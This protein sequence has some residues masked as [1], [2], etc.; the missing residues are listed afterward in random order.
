MKVYQFIVFFGIVLIIY[1]LVN[2]YIFSRFI[3]AIPADS[4]VR[5]WAII[6][7]WVLAF[8]FVVARI[9]ERAYPCDF[10][11]VMTWIGSF[12]LG[13]M[14]YFLMIVLLIDVARVIHHFL[15]FFPQIFYA[16]Y[17]KTKLITLLISMGLITMI[18]GA[19]FINARNTKIKVIDLQIEKKIKGEKTLKIAMASDIHLGTLVGRRGASR[20]VRMINDLHPDIILFAGDIVDEDLKPVIRRNLG[21]MLKTLHAPLGVWAVTGNHEY[22]GGAKEAVAYLKAH[23]ICFLSDT[24]VL[25]DDRF[26]LAGRE[27]RDRSRFMGKQRKPLEEILKDVDR[28]YPIILMDHQPFQLSVPEKL[29]VDLQLSG[30]THHGQIWPFNYITNAMYELSWGYLKKGNTQFYVSSGF[31]T[32]GPPVRLGNRPEIVSITLH[33]Q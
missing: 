31:G 20:L 15:P 6:A 19:G 30:H 12:W 7:F 23:N 1:G 16:D 10:T 3:Q 9:R 8:S 24:A 17:Q 28:S 14:V 22:I 11:E 21:E 5:I 27:D 26:Y 13:A 2:Y 25:I 33:L 18:V 4:S 29:G 32:W